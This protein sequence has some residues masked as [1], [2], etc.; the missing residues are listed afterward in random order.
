M[1]PEFKDRQGNQTGPFLLATGGG[2]KKSGHQKKIPEK[3][4]WHILTPGG[5]NL[6]VYILK[7]TSGEKDE[8]KTTGIWAPFVRKH[9][10]INPLNPGR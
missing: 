1:T 5:K 10:T 2:R 3:K 4:G 9:M 8:I 7:G 6:R